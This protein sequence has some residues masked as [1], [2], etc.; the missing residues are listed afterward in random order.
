MVVSFYG[1]LFSVLPAFIADTFGIK[2]AGAIHGRLLTAWAASALV[3]PSILTSLRG[4]SYLQA[5]VDLA[6][7]CNPDVFQQKFGAGIDELDLLVEAKTV[8]IAKL[9]EILPQGT[10]DPTPAIYDS[11]MY[12]MAG[13][14]GCALVCNAMIH[15]FPKDSP[16]FTVDEDNVDS[17]GK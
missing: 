6:A 1:G 16:Y 14:M 7:Q 11:T 15:P 3:G 13:I 2:H 17:R 4:N 5:C 10:V 9:L 8:T 12:T